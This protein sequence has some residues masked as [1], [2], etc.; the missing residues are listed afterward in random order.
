MIRVVLGTVYTIRYQYIFL[1]NNEHTEQVLVPFT[2]V[3]VPF[4]LVLSIML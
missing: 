3:F 1:K 2:L 4:A